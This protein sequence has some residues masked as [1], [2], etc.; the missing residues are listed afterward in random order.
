[1][2]HAVLLLVLAPA[3][4][5]PAKSKSAAPSAREQFLARMRVMHPQEPNTTGSLWTS[6]SPFAY[7]ASDAKA[8]SAGDLLTIVVSESTSATNNTKL[9]GSRKGTVAAQVSQLG[10][11]LHA[12]NALNNLYSASSAA[13]LDSQG[14]SASAN[15]LQTV[16][17]AHVLEALPNGLLAVEGTRVLDID[18]QRQTVTVRGLVRQID[19]LPDN[20]IPSTALGDL[21]VE[22]KGKGAVSDFTNPL[23]PVVRFVVRWLGI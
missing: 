18:H 6:G 14:A 16:M 9:S 4:A 15:T 1:V 13:T 8:R 11:K 22:V 23:N 21:E 3:L 5:W 2:R 17:T 19:I 20:S 10:G 7:L 12:G